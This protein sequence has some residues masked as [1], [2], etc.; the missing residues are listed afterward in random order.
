MINTNVEFGYFYGLWITPHLLEE[1]AELYSN[2]YGFWSADAPDNPGQMIRLSA[3]RIKEWVKTE[4]AAIATARLDNRLIGYAVAIRV[5]VKRYGIVTWITQLVVHK[6]FRKQG[7][8]KRLLFSFW[9]FSD[10]FAWGIVSANPFAIRAL[11]KATRRRVVASRVKKHHDLLLG[12]ADDHVPYISRETESE[13]T[14]KISRVNTRFY[15]D[16]SE[17]PARLK[18]ASCS[19]PWTLG[20]LPPG[21]EWLAFTFSDQPQLELTP[22]EI[23]FMLEASDDVVRQAY[24]RMTLDEDHK[25]AKNTEH[26]VDFI[27]KTCDLKLGDP[28]LDVGCGNG[29]HSFALASRGIAVTGIDYVPSLIEK[30]NAAKGNTGDVPLAYD[31]ADFRTTTLNSTFTSIICIYDVVGSFAENAQ[32]FKILRN[33]Y[34][35]LEPGGKALLSVMNSVLTESI[36]KHRFSLKTDPSAL[37]KLRPSRTMESSGDVFNPDYFM[38]DTESG[39]VYRKEQFEQGHELPVE[40]IVRDRRYKPDEISHL[41]AAVGLNVLWTRCVRSGD[42]ETNLEPD[43]P[44]AKEILILCQK[45]K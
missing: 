6:D 34:R 21:W 42:W 39:V 1:C 13:V 25:W 11:E 22:Q 9:E 33:I 44:R 7:V 24:S 19:V 27:I 16:H 29:R 3:N 36:A 17:L 31:V 43:N 30:A 4:E 26:E 28:L 40:L 12:V 15:V 41:C 37:L 14:Q 35:H 32:N 18:A 20:E 2:H 23:K 5:S 8:A 45:P 10:H 38:I